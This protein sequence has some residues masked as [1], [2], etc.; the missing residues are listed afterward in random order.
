MRD[1]LEHAGRRF[2]RFTTRVVV[3]RPALWRVFRP[4][5]R[6]QFD[7]LAPV[8]ESRRT[9]EPVEAAL[10][11]V[12]GAPRR[13]LDLGTGTGLAARV[14]GGRYPEAEVVGADLSQAMIDEARRL[15]PAALAGRVRFERADGAALPY[16][17]GSFD[18]VL[19]VNMI[20]FFDE[21]ARVT[22][23]DGRVLFLSTGGRETP[24][25][26]PPET[27]TARLRPLGFRSFDE[28]EAAGATGLIAAKE[29][30]S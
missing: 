7:R 26:V 27:L 3:A 8:W 22:A 9:P 23:P 13:I 25:Y 4:L 12:G 1:R 20:P 17:D 2:A 15:L 14:A 11:R 24:I 30:L 18:L 28:L 29:R 10:D 5:T 21:L 16:S 6:A 19:L